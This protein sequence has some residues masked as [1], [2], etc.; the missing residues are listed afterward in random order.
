MNYLVVKEKPLGDER[1][2]KNGKASDNFPEREKW[3]EKRNSRTRKK[4]GGAQSTSYN[5]GGKKKKRK[6]SYSSFPEKRERAKKRIK[7]FVQ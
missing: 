7:K 2:K 1:R 6:F 4:E 5:T 3:E